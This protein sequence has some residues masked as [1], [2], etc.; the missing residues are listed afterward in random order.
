MLRYSLGRLLLLAP[1][2]FGLSVLTFLY[3]RLI[4]G[5][6]I[7][8]MLGPGGSPQLIHELREKFRLDDPVLIQYGRWIA[9]LV[10]HGDLGV[11]FGSG[12][13]ITPMLIN[14]IPATLQLT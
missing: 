3:L 11:S 9:N 14:R 2:L 4:P 13:A 5:D 1:L 8:G 12:Q 6:P 7:A 10:A